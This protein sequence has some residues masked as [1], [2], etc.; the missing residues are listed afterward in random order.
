[1]LVAFSLRLCRFFAGSSLQYYLRCSNCTKRCQRGHGFPDSCCSHEASMAAMSTSAS[2]AMSHR[3][4]FDG[5]PVSSLIHG[6]HRTHGTFASACGVS[7][8]RL[9]VY[10]RN[11]NSLDIFWVTGLTTTLRFRVQSKLRRLNT[12]PT[13]CPRSQHR[14]HLRFTTIN[15]AALP[16]WL[17]SFQKS[18][19]KSGYPL[20]KNELPYHRCRWCL[21]Q[22][23][24]SY[25]DRDSEALDWQFKNTA[26]S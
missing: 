3:L 26:T 24:R 14:H 25:K 22:T 7:F 12:N 10:S 17:E 13:Q 23:N 8:G 1:M 15:A 19:D 9:L 16:P 4:V 6:L 18:I 21:L 20:K 11:A 2:K 5:I